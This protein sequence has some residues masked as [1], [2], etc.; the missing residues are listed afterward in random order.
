MREAS[1][2]DYIHNLNRYDYSIWKPIRNTRKPIE[3]SPPIREATPNVRPWARSNQEKSELFAQHFARI[4]TP[5]NEEQDQAIEQN[6]TTPIT[7]QQTIT[8]ATPNE[9]KEAIKSMGL[10]KA[11]GPDQITPKMMKE[12]PKKGIVL[13]TYIFNGII[14]MFYWPKQI[15]ISQVIPIAKPGKDPTVVTSYRPISLISVLSKVFEKLLLRRINKDLRPDEWIPHHQF[16]FRQGHSTI[17]QIHRIT[18]IINK[19]YEARKYCTAVFLDVSQAFDRV[20]HSGLLFKIKQTLPPSYFNLFKSY[21]SDRQF[22]IKVGNEKS[23]PQPIKAGVPQGSVLGPT[24]YT[25]FTSD[26]PTSPDKSIGTFADDIAIL[27]TNEDPERAA[28]NLQHHL[29]ALQNWFEK[30]RI[31]INGNKSCYITFTLQKGLTPDVYINNQQIPRKTEVKYLGMTMDNK[32]TWKQHII[33]KRKQVDLTVKKLNWLI[34]KKSKL[35]IANKILI[36]KTIIIPIWTYGLELWGCSS[37]SNITIIQRSQSK[38]LR[39]IADAPWY[40]SNATL[41]SDLGISTVQDV[42]KRKSTRHHTKIETHTNPLIRALRAREDNRR[43]KRNW[44]IDL[45]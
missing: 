11:P 16:G 32:L 37:K 30:W 29:S 38:I 14:R 7:S 41:H 42:I 35:S 4:F 25:L 3:P 39:M 23:E 36:Y 13:L 6:L 31:R 8:N 40:V 10:K 22:Q 43:L 19:A 18:N 24:L 21:L 20:W 1:F 12:L 33:K 28:L 34:G 17:Q 2:A 45:M 5:H 44:P 26:L 15:K 9:I 27:T